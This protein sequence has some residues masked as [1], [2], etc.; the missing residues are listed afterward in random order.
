VSQSVPLQVSVSV[1]L[2]GSGNGT[3]QAGPQVAGV[4]W[5]PAAAGVLVSPVSTTVVSLFKLYLGQAQ[6]QNFLGGSYTGDNNSAGLA[7]TLYPGQVITGTWTGGNPGATATL[8]LSGTQTI[9]GT[10]ATP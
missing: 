4:S 10:G 3:V 5:Q 6:P 9:P 8:T 1:V 7:V 2:D